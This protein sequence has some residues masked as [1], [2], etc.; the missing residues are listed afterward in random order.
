MVRRARFEP[1]GDLVDLGT[2][3]RTRRLP[4]PARYQCLATLGSDATSVASSFLRAN[5][6]RLNKNGYA[7]NEEIEQLAGVASRDSGSEARRDPH[8]SRICPCPEC[9]V[10]DY[11]PGCVCL[12]C[13]AD[14]G[15]AWRRYRILPRLAPLADG[16]ACAPPLVVYLQDPRGAVA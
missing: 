6:T 11:R 12:S 2:E 4:K 16:E 3:A 15:R 1:R 14:P 13:A 8:L 9:A 7:A 10:H 5:A